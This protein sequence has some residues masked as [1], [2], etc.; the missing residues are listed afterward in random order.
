[1]GNKKKG[2]RIKNDN[3]IEYKNNYILWIDDEINTPEY[4]EKIKTLKNKNIGTIIPI[5]SPDTFLEYIN[6][7][8]NDPEKHKCIIL[9]LH[10]KS[11]GKGVFEKISTGTNVGKK[12]LEILK[13]ENSRWKNILIVVFTG[14]RAAGIESLYY[15]KRVIVL[16]KNQYHPHPSKLAEEIKKAINDNTL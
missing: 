2:T 6:N 11:S 5:D 7:S 15:G 1:M 14:M 16:Q 3:Q 13:A 10:F 4:E 9:D 8:N 12:I